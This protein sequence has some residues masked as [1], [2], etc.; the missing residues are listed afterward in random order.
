M[1]EEKG[2]S[3]DFESLA[4]VDTLMEVLDDEDD[5]DVDSEDIDNE[6]VPA[7][8]PQESFKKLY[9]KKLRVSKNLHLTGFGHTSYQFQ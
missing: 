8:T 3:V 1:C 2:I 7:Y 4:D 9:F 6:G 5:I